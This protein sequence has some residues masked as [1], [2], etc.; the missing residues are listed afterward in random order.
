MVRI[1]LGTVNLKT[2][3]SWEIVGKFAKDQMN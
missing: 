3:N 1:A 2:K